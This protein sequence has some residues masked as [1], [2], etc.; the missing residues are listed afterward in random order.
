MPTIENRP[1]TYYSSYSYALADQWR[2]LVDYRASEPGESER[3]ELLQRKLGTRGW[4]RFL[5]F[6]QEFSRSWGE[7]GKGKP[8]SP[9]AQGAFFKFL[10]KAEFPEG[11]TPSIFL[12]SE[13]HVEL[14]WEN[15]VGK[16]IQVEFGPEVAEIYLETTGYETRIKNTRMDDVVNVACA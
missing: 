7:E 10:Q 3:E 13:G 8:F 15:S 16:A 4:G 12:T 1:S 9:K 6:K 2:E 5:Y 14:S 11:I